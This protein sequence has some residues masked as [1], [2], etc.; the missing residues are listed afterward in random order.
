M[1]IFKILW[2][3]FL[4]LTLAALEEL[5]TLVQE[6][7]FH[8]QHVLCHVLNERQEAALGV[9]PRVRSQLLLVRLEALDDSRNSEL[10]VAFC[11]VQ[12]SARNGESVEFDNVTYSNMGSHS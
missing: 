7:V 9:V 1:K 8:H 12:C 2:C 3:T 6:S 11:A 10:V 4:Q 5:N